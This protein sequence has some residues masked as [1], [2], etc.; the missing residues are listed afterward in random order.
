M[1]VQVKSA[2]RNMLVL[3]AAALVAGVL[4]YLLFRPL[5]AALQWLAAMLRIAPLHLHAPAIWLG[6]IPSLL[7]VLGFSLLT[8]AVLGVRRELWVRVPASW[9]VLNVVFE[10]GQAL[11][12]CGG[13]L[14]AP[15]CIWLGTGTFD[16]NDLVASA[17]GAALAMLAVRRIAASNAR[18]VPRVHQRRLRWLF[19]VMLVPTGVALITA[20]T[21]ASY[22]KDPVYLSYAELRAAVRV[23]AQHALT[24]IGKVYVYN[25][26]LLLNAPNEGVHVY[27]NSDPTAPVYRAFINIPG[28]LD[29][30]VK[31]GYLYADSFIDLVVLDIRDLSAITVTHRSEDVF[32][33]D[34]YQVFSNETGFSLST[35]D[36][37]KGVVV[38]YTDAEGRGCAS[39]TS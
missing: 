7:H 14:D 10:T 32:P 11:L 20:S 6:S 35:V 19:I 4:F 23:D 34:A 30:A 9:F 12:R 28:N 27:D 21:C 25:N 13:A 22:L 17:L 15:L 39:A 29:V 37:S 18:P 31:D 5:P 2:Q 26:L 1:S 24:K 33:Y 8:W 3:G 38:G 36:K 16:F